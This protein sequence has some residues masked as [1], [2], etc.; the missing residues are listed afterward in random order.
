MARRRLL[1]YPSLALDYPLETQRAETMSGP[2]RER[3]SPF[4]SVEGIDQVILQSQV[5]D[6]QAL[7]VSSDLMTPVMPVK[8][9]QLLHTTAVCTSTRGGRPIVRDSQATSRSGGGGVSVGPSVGA[10]VC[11]R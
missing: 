1:D 3:V 6:S 11:D 7:V 8:D 9:R 5:N 4:E 2:L 10:G